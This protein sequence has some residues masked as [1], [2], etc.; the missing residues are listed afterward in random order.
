MAA[1]SELASIQAELQSVKR[2]LQSGAAHL[3]LQGEALQ[4]YLLQLNEKENL[5]LSKQLRNLAVESFEPLLPAASQ[6]SAPPNPARG[7]AHTNGSHQPRPAPAGE[8]KAFNREN[9][10]EVLSHM[11]EYEAVPTECAKALKALSSLAYAN[12]RSI[13]QDERVLPSLLRVARL[14]STEGVVQLTAMRAISNMAYDQEIALTRL[15]QPD[16]M[17]QLLAA[18]ASK[19]EP[20]EISARASEALARIIAAEVKPDSDGGGPPPEQPVQLPAGSPG[21]LCGLFLAACR[22]EAACKEIVPQL[23]TQLS[24]NEV[25]EARQAAEGFTRCEQECKIPADGVGWLSLAKILSPVDS[26]RDLPAALVEAGAIRAAASIMTRFVDDS[27]VQLTGIEAMSS[28]VGNRWAGLRA[29]ADVGGMERV[30]EAMRRHGQDAVIQTKG[31]RALGSGVQWPQ[32]I[33][34]RAR[35]SHRRAVEITKNAMSQ[36]GS[37]IELQIAALEALAKY[38]D[39]TKCVA[40][41]KEAGGEG[42][43]KMMMTTHRSNA[44][45]QQWGQH[46][47]T[48]IGADPNWAPKT[49]ASP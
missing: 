42:L 13:G 26:V 36:H 25:T 40:D 35:Y 2:A 33:Q 14:H 34:E 32:D 7:Y 12:A 20:K 37:D 17:G 21:A 11:A 10:Q 39:K 1:A 41:I 28:L 22:G 8:A 29:F 31:V 16:V 4:K 19:A 45:V 47:L 23:L 15:A 38:L 27:M 30:E 48:G 5:L 9:V 6:A 44:K 18:M 46:V 49:G 3:G 43:V 24:S